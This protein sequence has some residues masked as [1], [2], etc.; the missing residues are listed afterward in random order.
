MGTMLAYLF[1]DCELSSAILK[2]LLSDNIQDTFN[3]ISVDSDT[4]TSD[5]VLFFSNPINKINVNKN[6]NKISKTLNKVMK[7]LS[8]KIITDG[9]GIKKLIK[10]NVNKAKNKIQAKELLLMLK[11]L[12]FPLQTLPW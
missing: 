12:L 3:S 8:I 7:E 5:T 1:I 10:V 6:Y 2:K 4:S 11:K 9:E